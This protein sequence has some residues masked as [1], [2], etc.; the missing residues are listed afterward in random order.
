MHLIYMTN[1]TKVALVTGASSGIG[2]AT[3]AL[4]AEH[5]FTVFGTS[6]DPARAAPAEGVELIALDVRDGASVHA[7]VAEVL[8]RAGRIDVVVNN[9]GYT[10]LG[11]VEETTTEQARALFDTNF[12]GAVRVAAAVLPTMRAQGSGRII[13]MSSVVGFVPAPY[14]GFYSA[15][16][17]A[18][19]GWAE[20]LDHEVRTLGVR[21]LLIEPG[22]TH[23]GIDQ[24]AE[25]ARSPLAAYQ[26]Q[27]RT[28]VGA[29][30]AGVAAAVS[31][32]VVAETVLRAATARSPRLRWR[33]DRPAKV[34]G[35]LRSLVPAALFD[36]SLRKR[37]RLDAAP[38]R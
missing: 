34:L 3:A 25:A 13:N 23:T 36:A 16:K 11:A 4:L 30:S 21:V 24:N 6:R 9:A 38:A 33:P 7:A 37:F 28:V 27:R 20:S 14:M 31:P 22:F 2:R 18:L 17:H 5:G 1:A 15:S 10:V 35:V 8:A 19:E 32:E 29:I 26:A 12:F